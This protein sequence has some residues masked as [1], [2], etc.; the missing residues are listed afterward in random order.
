MLL[1]ADIDFTGLSEEFNPIGLGVLFKTHFYGSFDGQRHTI[2]NLA[3]N[4]SNQY[5][6]IFGDMN[7]VSIKN[8]V[9]DS[10]CSFTNSFKLTGM[11]GVLEVSL[12]VSIQT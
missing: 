12:G 6:G 5:V 11:Q 9:V 1:A 2:S 8:I 10:S 4:S 3:M 7:G